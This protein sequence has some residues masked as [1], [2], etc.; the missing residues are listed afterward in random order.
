[1]N[2]LITAVKERLDI[3]SENISIKLP[4]QYPKWITICDGE[5]DMPQ[6]ITVDT[7]V[8]VFIRM[9]RAIDE[10]GVFI[11][12][13]SHRGKDVPLPHQVERNVGQEREDGGENCMDEEE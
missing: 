4:Y 11:V 9:R 8:G 3:T 10:V 13:H 5:L 12:R 6:Y 1:M 7:E 2:E